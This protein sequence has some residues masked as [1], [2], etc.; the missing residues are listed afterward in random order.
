MRSGDP[1][2]ASKQGPLDGEIEALERAR[3]EAR[4]DS[5]DVQL[6]ALEQKRVDAWRSK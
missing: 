4:K 6:A 1:R 3:W 5:V 2:A